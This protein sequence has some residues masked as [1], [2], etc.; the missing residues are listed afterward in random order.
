MIVFLKNSKLFLPRDI[1]IL[2]ARGD[3]SM[4]PEELLEFLQLIS[5][6]K[7]FKDNLVLALHRPPATKNILQALEDYPNFRF[8]TTITPHA[9]KLGWAKVL[10]EKQLERVKW[11]I[12]SGIPTSRISIEVG[13]MNSLNIN[14]GIEILKQLENMEFKDVIVRGMAFGSFGVDRQ[15]ELGKMLELGFITKEMLA[16]KENHE[17]YVIKNF[18]TPKAYQWI[19]EQVPEMKIHRYTYTFYRDV[20]D[21]PIANNRGNQVRVSAPTQLS[22]NQVA[23]TVQKYGL[24]VENVERNKDHYFITLREGTQAATE[25]ISMT[26]GAELQTALIFNNYHRTATIGDVRFYKQH[27]LFYLDPYLK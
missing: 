25:D 17:Y 12:E 6:D 2:G 9:F 26:I 22:E 27:S 11:L 14:T 8:G 13:P 1:L 15:K 7:Y 3:A 18:L 4:Y 10:E 5:D 16:K 19:Q 20:W 21:V 24:E 23:K